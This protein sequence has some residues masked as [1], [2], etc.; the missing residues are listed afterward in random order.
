VAGQ[1]IVIGGTSGS[2]KSSTAKRWVQRSEDFWL[3]YGIDAFLSE[4]FPVRFQYAGT[5]YDEGVSM[6]PADPSDPQGPLRWRFGF[7]GRKGLSLIHEW[8]ATASRM[9]C[10]VVFDQLMSVDPPILQ[11][12]IWRMKG[13]PVLFVQLKP[14]LDVLRERVMTRKIDRPI[15]QGENT[16][17]DPLAE[18]N[19]MLDRMRPWFYES[20]YANEICDLEID[21][22]APNID[23]VCDLIAA[24]LAE[25][26]GT[27]FSKLRDIYPR[28]VDL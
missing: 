2:G 4:S 8:I 22:S 3:L 15:P 23:A 5:R 11:D 21:T 9:G 18:M 13:L 1:I 12:C 27:A 14:P 28:P 6:G 19:A 24:R 25:G 7:Y 20:S 16:G 17:D 10:N 26:P